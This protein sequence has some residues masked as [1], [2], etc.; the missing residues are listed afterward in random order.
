MISGKYSVKNVVKKSK[1]NANADFVLLYSSSSSSILFGSLF[2][3]NG[4]ILP[5]FFPF[6]PLQSIHFPPISL[7]I[8]LYSD[9]G[10]KT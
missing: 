3:C 10:S 7:H 2:T 6:P 8:D 5:T 9:S 1:C 4:F